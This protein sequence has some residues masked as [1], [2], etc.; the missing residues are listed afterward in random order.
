[1]SSY[2]CFIRCFLLLLVVPALATQ[3]LHGQGKAGDCPCSPHVRR[4]GAGDSPAHFLCSPE[5]VA[6]P[7]DGSLRLADSVLVAD[8]IGATDYRQTQTITDRI[9]AKKV[10]VLDSADLT[11]AELFIYGS[12]NTIK[13][14]G[15]P[16][17]ACEP[18]VST[19]WSRVKVS[20]GNLKAGENEFIFS[21]S[22]SLLLNQAGSPAAAQ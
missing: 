22:G 4:F 14:N 3:P 5:V 19:A 9:W 18:L 8:E 13:V 16:L 6:D 21:G 11:A 15:K 17:P 2:L 7:R 1:M 12:A 20:P 10:L